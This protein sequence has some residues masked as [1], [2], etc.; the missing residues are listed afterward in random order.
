MA[1]SSETKQHRE[2]KAPQNRIEESPA[3]RTGGLKT[4]F[5]WTLGLLSVCMMLNSTVIFGSPLK[6]SDYLQKSTQRSQWVLAEISVKKA[7]DLVDR[8]VNALNKLTLSEMIASAEKSFANCPTVNMKAPNARAEALYQ[9]GISAPRS[10]EG[11]IAF[12]EAA[13]LGY[14]RA[15][16]NLVSIALEDEDFESAY[17]ITAW[18]IKHKAPSA[19]SKLAITLKTITSYYFGPSENTDSIESKLQ[20]KSAMAGDPVSM[21]ELGNK[22][23]SSGSPKLGNK[24]IE[25]AKILRPDLN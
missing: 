4:V 15:A 1:E 18:L 25:C 11:E 12:I 22:L 21:F 9:K 3:F 23:L 24:M 19:H 17:I 2:P 10:E 5:G 13:K 7:K 20:L 14:W 6:M 16:S 8:E